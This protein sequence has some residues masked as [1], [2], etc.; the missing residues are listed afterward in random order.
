MDNGMEMF[1][2]HANVWDITVSHNDSN[3]VYAATSNYGVLKTTNGG[4][5][6]SKVNNGLPEN[7]T[8]A[9]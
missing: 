1:P 9:Q 2:V 8:T 4:Q 5:S 6:W 7:K 3:H